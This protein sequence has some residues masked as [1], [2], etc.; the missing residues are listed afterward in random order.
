MAAEIVD[1]EF[2]HAAYTLRFPRVKTIR[3]DKPWNETATFKEV[4][5]MYVKGGW[6]PHS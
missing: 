2:Y 3:F 5:V 4:Q 6:V 1:A